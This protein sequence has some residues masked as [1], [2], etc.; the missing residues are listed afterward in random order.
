[1]ELEF[2]KKI[3]NQYKINDIVFSV[4]QNKTGLI[5]Q[6][7][8]LSTLKNKYILQEINTKVFPS[9]QLGLE[10]IILIKEWLK[11]TNYSY[12]FPSPILNQYMEFDYKVWRL[13]PFINNS[14]SI[15]RV[16]K[17]TQVEE[18]V[19]CVSEFYNCLKKFPIK[20][21]NVTL[22][23]FH[24]GKHKILA[25]QKAL[26]TANNARK[27]NAQK[28]ILEIKK[29]LALLVQWD[30]IC[31]Q[32]PVRVVHYDTKI[33]NFLFENNNNKVIALIDF[34][35]LMPGCILSDIGDMI[36]TYSNPAG[37]E[38][39]ELSKVICN[40]NIVT[41]IL[42]GFKTSCELEIKEKQNMFFGGLAI[43][44]MQSI[45]FLTDYLN[46]DIYYNINYENQN[47]V[48]AN[49]QFRLYQSLRKFMD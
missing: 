32:L 22:Q 40:R 25:F 28:L 23:N 33:N 16:T 12:E 21:L 2:A 5:N 11:K 49:N 45:R 27:K 46:N 1:V 7:F 37:E 18:A 3:F 42:N 17:I 19:S 31:R 4:N 34:D 8:E 36:R 30:E 47:L 44:L 10:N 43:T 15:D 41:S 14:R 39:S 24:S 38:S 35:T 9:Y 26:K 20:K 29:S 13:L 6:T 48:R